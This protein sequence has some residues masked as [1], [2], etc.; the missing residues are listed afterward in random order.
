MC[1]SFAFVVY[2]SIAQVKGCSTVFIAFCALK[3]QLLIAQT[4]PWAFVRM[5]GLK[6]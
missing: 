2:A 5:S 1:W 3:G 4:T 6:A